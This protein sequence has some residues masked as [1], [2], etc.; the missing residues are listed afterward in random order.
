M[1]RNDTWDDFLAKNLTPPPFLAQNVLKIT[2]FQASPSRLSTP[3]AI[4]TSIVESI[5]EF[6]G[7]AA[8]ALVDVFI[9]LRHTLTHVFFQQ[10]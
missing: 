9:W 2:P 7:L 10:D 1:P 5:R 3:V 6:V 4:E 8:T